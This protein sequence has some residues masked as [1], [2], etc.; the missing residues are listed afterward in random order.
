MKSI[1]LFALLVLTTAPLFGH[2][3]SVR[4]P[5]IADAALALDKGDV[6]PVLKWVR[7]ADESEIR[8]AFTQAVSVR[9]Q[10]PEAK[11]V[12][13]RWFFETLVRVHRAGEG[14]PFTGLKGADFEVEEGIELA[15]HALESGSLDAAEKALL[16]TVTAGLRK[17]FQEVKEARAHAADSVEAG[18]AYVHAYV[19]FIH[20]A[21]RLHEAAT[22]GAGHGAAAEHA[23]H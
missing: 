12:A 6:T 19:E 1:C 20:Y 17:R 18:R 7:P 2:C 11:A 10:S 5:V 3:D 23:G 13:D 15:D 14:A 9:A 8:A 21:E 4:G 22:L 16:G